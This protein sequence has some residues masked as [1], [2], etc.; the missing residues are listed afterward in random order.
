MHR[1]SASFGVIEAERNDRLVS[2][3]AESHTH[4]WLKSLQKLEPKLVDEIE[5]FFVSYN[6]ARGKSS[7]QSVEKG[8][9]AAKRLIGRHSTRP[10][11]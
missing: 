2:V 11:D 10:N 9:V 1:G 6:K 8:P 5:H 4:G 3:A 7:S